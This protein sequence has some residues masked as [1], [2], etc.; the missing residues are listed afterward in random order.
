[1]NEEENNQLD[2]MEANRQNN[3]ALKS[4]KEAFK[5]QAKKQAKNQIMK[6]IV[7][8]IV[9]ALLTILKFLLPII[10]ITVIIATII[11]T[12]FGG[13]DGDDSLN[14]EDMEESSQYLTLGEYLQQ[15]S[16]SSEAPQSEDG[17]FYKMYGDGAGWPTIGN[18]DLQWKSHSTSFARQGKV[19]KSDGEYTVENVEEYVNEFLTRGSAAKYTN[20]E[21]DAMNIYIE[22][23]LV[24]E[25]GEEV[26][27]GTYQYVLNVT[28]GL[29]L[30]QQQLYALTAIA[31]NFGHLPTRNGYTFKSVYEEATALYPINSAEHNMYVWD[32]WWSKVGGGYA[33]HVPARDAA[34]ETYVKGVYDFTYSDAGEVFGRKYYIYYTQEQLDWL[35]ENDMNEGQTVPAKEVT[36]TEENESQIFAYEEFEPTTHFD[37]ES[38]QAH[39]YTFPHYL[40]KNY[41]GTFGT[42]T[43][44][45][46]GCGPTSMAMILAGL[47]NDFSIT[48]VTFIK[49]LDEYFN[50]DYT[51]YYLPGTGSI[52]SGLCNSDFLQKYYN[53]KSTYV[54]SET[55]AWEAIAAGKCIIGAEKGHILAIIPLPDEYLKVGGYKFYILDSARGHSGAFTSKSDFTSSTGAEYLNTWYIIEKME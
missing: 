18:S 50:G 21:V 19:L 36:R 33:G 42:S 27:E 22:K 13:D 39:G 17:R 44:S 53:C 51:K 47:C 14:S 55:Q 10:I 32:N 12:L 37:G 28:E 43:I 15:F 31:Y 35:Q 48:P 40:Q 24:D 25:I 8:A 54:T 34:F 3:L 46:S 4:G 5:R 52:Y 20:E 16:H 30:S 11:A 7:K 6:V 49:N 23:D 26:A 41:S 1:M 38:V 29:D 9:A 2:D 45:A